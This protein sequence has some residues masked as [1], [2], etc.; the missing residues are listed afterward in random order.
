MSAQERTVFSE[1]HRHRKVPGTLRDSHGTTHHVPPQARPAE[2]WVVLCP[3]E[4]ALQAGPR[5]PV[6]TCLQGG[7]SCL[8]TPAP[9][10]HGQGQYLLLG[11]LGQETP[12]CLMCLAPSLLEPA[13][14]TAWAGVGWSGRAAGPL[15][16]AG[17]ALLGAGRRGSQGSWGSDPTSSQLCAA[18]LSELH[19]C[20]H[21][22][23]HRHTHTQVYACTHMHTHTLINTRAHNHPACGLRYTNACRLAHAHSQMPTDWH[24]PSPPA[25]WTHG[26]L[27][28]CRR[29]LD[30]LT[31]LG[32]LLFLQPNLNSLP[33]PV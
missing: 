20:K 16:A 31:A 5:A 33:G 15:Y 21:S 7:G 3:G 6:L 2:P 24:M 12:E 26:G 1:V 13:W 10:L 32:W 22:Q 30:P 27:P 4:G 18:P 9:L 14:E 28:S 29:G 11:S 25:L 8:P 17:A 23:M 19:T